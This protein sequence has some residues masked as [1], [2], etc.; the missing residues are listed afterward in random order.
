MLCPVGYLDQ[1]AKETLDDLRRLM[2]PTDDPGVLAR[3][4]WIIEGLLDMDPVLRAKLIGKEDRSALRRV[5]AL[6]QLALSPE[7]EAR[8]DACDD[9]DI[10]RRWLDQAVLAASTAEALR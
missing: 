3:R 9:I 6:R 1:F 10:L 7:D 8:I 5:L 2:I 4:R